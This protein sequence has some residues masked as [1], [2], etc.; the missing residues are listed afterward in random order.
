LKAATLPHYAKCVDI[1]PG[2]TM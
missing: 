2:L 1:S